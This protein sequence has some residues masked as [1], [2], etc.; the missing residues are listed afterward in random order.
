MFLSV[1]VAVVSY[2]VALVR[3]SEF[4]LHFQYVLL[5][6]ALQI[7][8]I[9][10]WYYIRCWMHAC[11]E[12]LCCRSVNFTLAAMWEDTWQFCI[13]LSIRVMG[14][15]IIARTECVVCV[16]I[17]LA[18]NNDQRKRKTE[19]FVASHPSLFRCFYCCCCSIYSLFFGSSQAIRHVHKRLR[20]ALPLSL[21]PPISFSFSLRCDHIFEKFRRFND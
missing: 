2:C 15:K 3:G 19:H 6:N 16:C 18:T 14:K 17:V 1:A 12:C 5:L 21:S 13:T 20:A 4:S 9:R 10:K 11:V 8:Y 7:Q